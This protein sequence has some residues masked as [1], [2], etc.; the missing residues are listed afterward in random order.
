MAPASA[1]GFID[2]VAS[3]GTLTRLRWPIPATRTALSTEECV[4]AL[5]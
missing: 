1:P 5:A 4:S 3:V 2:R